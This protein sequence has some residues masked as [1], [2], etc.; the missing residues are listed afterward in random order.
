MH[1]PDQHPL[2]LDLIRRCLTNHIHGGDCNLMSNTLRPV[3]DLVTGEYLWLRADIPDVSQKKLGKIWPSLAHTMIGESRL[4]H[5]QQCVE[6]IIHNQIPGDLIET[7]V[8]RGGAC[9]LMRAV[10]KAYGITD[11][12][13]WLADSFAGIPTVDLEK[14][15]ADGH[16][17]GWNTASPLAISLAEVRRHFAAYGL[18]DRQVVFLPGWFRDT[19]PQAPIES[20]ALLRLDGDLYESTW[21]ALESLYPKVSPS[22]IVI[23]DDYGYVTACR[24]AV[25]DYRQQEG[26]HTPLQWVDH[27]AVWWE[28]C[29]PNRVW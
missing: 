7:G 25:D 29:L 19:L 14:Y 26:I 23:V 12:R 4:L 16:C 18:L 5:L 3:Q 10:L 13:V 20:L 15:P 28:K 6:Q 11:R 24:Q 9:I 8:W 1:L 27:T 2:Y 21:L 17:L 22:G